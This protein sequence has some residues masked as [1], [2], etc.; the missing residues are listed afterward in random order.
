MAQHYYY[1]LLSND[2][3]M[4]DLT[5]LSSQNIKNNLVSVV[6]VA[7]RTWKA[8]CVRSQLPNLLHSPPYSLKKILFPGNLSSPQ[9]HRH[10]S[11]FR[12]YITRA[13][14]WLEIH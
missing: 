9:N 12:Q 2:Y 14:D 4:S 7:N 11:R 10:K 8:K 5:D 1:V 6:P 13:K 3:V